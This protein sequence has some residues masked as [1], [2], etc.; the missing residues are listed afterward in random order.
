MTKT[1]VNLTLSIVVREIEEILDT[2]PG[3]PYQQAFAIPDLR[4]KL[5]SYVLSRIP[6][7]YTVV[8]DIDGN[9]I[10][11]ESLYHSSQEKNH[12]VALIHQ[13]VQHILQEDSNWIDR[14]IP[15]QVSSNLAPSNWFG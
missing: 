8:D 4:Q 10:S 2:Y 3:H 11:V 5:I 12:V 7:H 15:Q 6:G 14:H 1:I 9:S 13:G